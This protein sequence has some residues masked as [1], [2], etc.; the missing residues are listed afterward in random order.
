MPQEPS[1]GSGADAAIEQIVAAVSGLR[2]GGA[3]AAE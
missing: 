2:S 3:L 1:T